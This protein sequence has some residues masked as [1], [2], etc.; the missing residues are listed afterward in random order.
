MCL[1]YSFNV[2]FQDCL[3]ATMEIAMKIRYITFIALLM[4]S[5]IA[6]ADY[7]NDQANEQANYQQ[8]QAQQQQ[9][10]AQQQQQEAQ[11]H[12]MQVQEQQQQFQRMENERSYNPAM[13]EV[14]SWLH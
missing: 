14:K 11:I 2:R 8:I 5:S 1:R 7:Y 4:A 13:N 9:M 10:Q 6:C 12:R 3:E